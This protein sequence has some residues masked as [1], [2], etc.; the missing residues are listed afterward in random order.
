MHQTRS[1]QTAVSLENL[2]P[3]RL[4]GRGWSEASLQLRKR[5]LQCMAWAMLGGAAKQAA[6]G[7]QIWKSNFDFGFAYFALTLG[8]QHLWRF[9]YLM[10]KNGG[11]NVLDKFFYT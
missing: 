10:Y 6:E 9:P 1:D 5:L 2:F 3:T 11:G 4:A 8:F 7:R